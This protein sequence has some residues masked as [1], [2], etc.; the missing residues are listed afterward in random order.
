[1][2]PSSTFEVQVPEGSG[3]GDVLQVIQP[4]GQTVQV[5]VPA[6]ITAGNVFIVN[7]AAAPP[8]YEHVPLA[9]AKPMIYEHGSTNKMN[10]LAS[11]MFQPTPQQAYGSQLVEFKPQVVINLQTPY[12][13]YHFI[14]QYGGSQFSC[15]NDFDICIFSWCLPICGAGKVAEFAMTP[16]NMP[17]SSCTCCAYA[18]MSYCCFPCVHG[19]IRQQLEL[20]LTVPGAQPVPIDFIRA[21]LIDSYCLPCCSVAQELRAIKNARRLGGGPDLVEFER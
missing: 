8:E 21:C 20:R 1:M 16:R 14:E 5:T 11:P 2:Y 7:M 15:D 13:G 10:T 4:D 9:E 19:S 3:P 18:F 17:P 6:N 12:Q